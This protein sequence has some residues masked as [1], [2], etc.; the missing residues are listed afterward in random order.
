MKIEE[1]AIALLEKQGFQRATAAIRLA[2]TRAWCLPGGF[3]PKTGVE[4]GCN[5]FDMVE[6]PA[7]VDLTCEFSVR[8]NFHRINLV[9]VKSKGPNGFKYR[10][11]KFS[12]NEVALGEML[13]PK[14]KLAYVNKDTGEIIWSTVEKAWQSRRVVCTEYVFTIRCF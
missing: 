2:I 6:A 9:E 1:T 3:N 10:K 7:N 12:L 4:T 8:K 5:A 13:G 11:V 14:L